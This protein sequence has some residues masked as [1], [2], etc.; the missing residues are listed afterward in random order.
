MKDE[1]LTVE[2]L[3][4]ELQHCNPKALVNIEGCDCTGEAKSVEFI[5]DYEI[6]IPLA[7]RDTMNCQICNTPSKDD[8][9]AFVTQEP[10]CSLCKINYIGGLPTTPE[11]IRQVREVLGLKPG[12]F[13]AVDRGEEARRILGR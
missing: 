4:A 7:N 9:F 10:V 1:Q 11:R 5:N 8:L 13:I 2:Q 6:L 12:E 3:I